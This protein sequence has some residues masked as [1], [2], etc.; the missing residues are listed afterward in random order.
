MVHAI[1]KARLDFYGHGKEKSTL[2]QLVKTLGLEK[3]VFVNDFVQDVAA[4]Y[5]QADC[6]VLTSQGEGFSLVVLE[7]LSQGCPVVAFDVNYGPSDLIQQDVNGYLVPFGDIEQ[8]AQRIIEV[9][10]NIHLQRRLKAASRVSVERFTTLAITERWMLLLMD[11][12]QGNAD[13]KCF[14]AITSIE[15]PTSDSDASQ[16]AAVQPHSIPSSAAPFEEIYAKNHWGNRETVSGSGSTLARRIPRQAPRSESPRLLA[17]LGGSPETLCTDACNFGLEKAG[18][19]PALRD[20][21]A[22]R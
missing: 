4:V 5:Q 14:H 8:L 22:P 20:L 16:T 17:S 12:C 7:S 18:Q 21:S 6:S 10:G 9:L 1:P 2:Q 19:P 15:M 13:S 11:V 3:S